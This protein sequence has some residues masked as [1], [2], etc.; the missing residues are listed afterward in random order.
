MQINIIW[1]EC[2]SMGAQYKAMI[3]ASEINQ[4]R[5]LGGSEF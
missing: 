3:N 4:E 1:T 5:F 2:I